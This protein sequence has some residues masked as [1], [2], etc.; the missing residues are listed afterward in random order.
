MINSFLIAWKKAFDFRGV[1]SRKDFW[2]YELAAFI[3]LIVIN[4]TSNLFVNLQ[5]ASLPSGTESAIS[6]EIFA[7]IA[8]ILSIISFLFVLGGI[9]VGLSISVRR[10]R[11][12]QKKWTWIFIQIIPLFGAIYFI[13]LMCQPSKKIID[14]KI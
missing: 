8:Q 9:L 5:Y 12:I 2:L 4:I 7:F 11:D 1:T 3:F 13:Y 14:Q 6:S 10:L